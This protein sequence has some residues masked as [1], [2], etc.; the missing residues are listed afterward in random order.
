[1]TTHKAREPHVRNVF[2]TASARIPYLL[3]SIK[4]LCSGLMHAP[5]HIVLLR[6]C[7]NT[8]RRGHEEESCFHESLRKRDRRRGESVWK[9]GILIRL[10]LELAGV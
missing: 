7:A 6:Q 5:S 3:L 10:L 8:I 1:M 2:S 4:P 9:A